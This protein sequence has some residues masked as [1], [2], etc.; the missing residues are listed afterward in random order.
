MKLRGMREVRVYLEVVVG[1]KKGDRKIRNITY[2]TT[3]S[4]T[5]RLLR[6]TYCLLLVSRFE[7][8]VF[9][10]ELQKLTVESNPKVFNGHFSVLATICQ[11]HNWLYKLNE[12]GCA[13]SI[14]TNH[15][16]LCFCYKATGPG[17]LLLCTTACL[18]PPSEHCQAPFLSL[19]PLPDAVAHTFVQSLCLVLFRLLKCSP[20]CW[21]PD[22]HNQMAAAG[23]E[24]TAKPS[25]S[26]Q[27]RRP[28]WQ[29]PV[30]S[31][32]QRFHNN[33]K[34]FS[35]SQLPFSFNWVPWGPSILIAPK[36]SPQRYQSASD[37]KFPCF[38]L[39]AQEGEKK[40][41]HI[42]FSH[43]VRVGKLRTSDFCSLLISSFHSHILPQD[44]YLSIYK[45]VL[46]V[47]FEKF[48]FISKSRFDDFHTFLLLTST[49]PC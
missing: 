5:R 8:M 13:D 26:H 30:W 37:N 17:C 24:P 11:V 19:P 35:L 34:G 16:R 43:W 41:T 1:H 31:G 28:V 3:K 22:Q 38:S 27:T 10:S 7:P 15:Q 18:F 23:T 32:R 4:K 40:E 6:K 12:N 44:K 14:T 45:C 36:H 25:C 20:F 29:S 9:P 42:F 21:S 2:T 49:L 46:C 47:N 39:K 33:S 48:Q